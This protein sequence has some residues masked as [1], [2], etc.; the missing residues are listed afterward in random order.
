MF[1]IPSADSIRKKTNDFINHE[2]L[3]FDFSNLFKYIV[4]QIDD[5]YKIANYIRIPFARLSNLLNIDQ[6][7]FKSNEYYIIKKIEN[8]FISLGYECTIRG[9]YCIPYD[10]HRF[11][12][13]S[14]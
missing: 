7:T 3:D 10:D 14:W 5:R 1:T 2:V 9:P 12:T 6:E 4:D 13:I 8:G 11:L